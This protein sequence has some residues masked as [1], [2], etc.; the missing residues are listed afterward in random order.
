MYTTCSRAAFVEAWENCWIF[1][2]SFVKSD[3]TMFD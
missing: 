2:P 3:V 1:S